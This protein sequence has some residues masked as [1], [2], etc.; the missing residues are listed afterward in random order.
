[1]EHKTCRENLSA[2]L[3]GELPPGERLAL[4]S[5]LTGCAECGRE[6]AELKRVSAI[7]K[8]HLMEPEPLSLRAAV[9]AKKREPVF[10]AW[11]KPAAV[12]SAAAAGLLIFLNLPKHQPSEGL[13]CSVG[14]PAAAPAAARGAGE[15]RYAAAAF[16]RKGTLAQAKFA[17]AAGSFSSF[18]GGAA[19]AAVF[20]GEATS[21]SALAGKAADKAKRA[22]PA[23]VPDVTAD[24]LRF[25]AAHWRE[26]AVSPVNGGSVRAFDARSGKFLWETRVYQIAEDADEEAD[27][28]QVHITE[29]ALKGKKLE[30][31]D[32]RGNRY[33]LDI[34]TRKADK[35]PR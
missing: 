31:T 24:G 25:S 9:F 28:Q 6:L 18:S 2:Y 32:E 13:S 20:P 19:P 29:L 27:V 34:S 35:L 15:K 22:A 7:V 23:E 1:M 8:K 11:L 12:L 16:A 4:E 26:N 33:L 14:S 21:L 10:S 30:I 17:G 5:H 3:D